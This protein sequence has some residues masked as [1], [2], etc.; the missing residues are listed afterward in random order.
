MTIQSIHV[1]LVDDEE[2]VRTPLAQHLEK[3]YKYVVETAAN[4]KETL[5][6]LNDSVYDV[7]LI[8]QI[9]DEET[10]SRE[11]IK[12]VRADF[13]ATQVIVL[14]GWAMDEGINFLRMGAYRYFAK[15]FNLEEL[16]LT[17][18]FAAEESRTQ[19]ERHHLA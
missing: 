2:S 6:L 7:A 1:L 17:I 15:P 10:D 4:A 13:P 14:T 19:Q 8:D 11:L 3:K 12:K 5:R 18:Q 16:A 9:L